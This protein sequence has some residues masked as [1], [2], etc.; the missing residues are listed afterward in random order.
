VKLEWRDVVETA[1]AVG[2][3][4]T[5]VLSVAMGGS[6]EYDGGFALCATAEVFFSCTAV[7]AV[8]AGYRP[9]YATELGQGMSLFQE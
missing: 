2:M 9:R 8:P 4:R 5:T 3:Y 1:K 7:G 6:D